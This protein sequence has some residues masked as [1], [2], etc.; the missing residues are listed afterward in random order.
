VGHRNDLVEPIWEYHH[1]IG[2]SITGGAVYRGTRF[3]ELAGAYLYG[4]YVSMKLW[5][6]QYDE[7]L[8]RV[9]AN[10]PIADPQVPILSF[11]EDDRGELYFMTYTTTGK[12][13][14]RF[15]RP[16]SDK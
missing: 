7:K 3:P 6:L 1:D 14:Y 16:S 11:G 10:R 15:A 2:K 4:D 5:A 12:G 9:V 13:I 8:R